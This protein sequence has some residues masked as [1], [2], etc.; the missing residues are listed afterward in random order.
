MT[1]LELIH[2]IRK[3]TFDV[4][5]V[6]VHKDANYGLERQTYSLWLV[7]KNS[8]DDTLCIGTDTLFLQRFVSER[9]AIL[10]AEKLNRWLKLYKGE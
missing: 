2:S 10:H 3:A 6:R 8:S 7:G 9:N 1:K 5:K 4:I